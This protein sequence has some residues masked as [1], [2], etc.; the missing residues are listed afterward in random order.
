MIKLKDLSL[1]V[2]VEGGFD[3]SLQDKIDELFRG[4]V[5][6]PRGEW[7]G[8]ASVHISE[9]NGNG[10]EYASGIFRGEKGLA[11]LV[12]LLELFTRD[13]GYYS[14]DSCG[15]HLHV[16][17]VEKGRFLSIYELIPLLSRFEWVEELQ[18]KA[19]KISQRQAKRLENTDN[20]YTNLYRDRADFKGNARNHAKY[21]FI[22][23]HTQGTLEF[24]FIFA[25]ENNEK[26]ETV[27]WVVD[28][29][30][31]ELQKTFKREF[32]EEISRAM[33]KKSFS[34]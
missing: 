19:K 9:G 17:L 22:C 6:H 10:H 8:D 13:N 21:K 23:Y 12:E 15:I 5:D 28:E 18:E 27:K 20:S 4:G 32:K 33:L 26:V 25:S 31:K 1:G 29:V 34:Y 3:V 14:N 30:L 24:R 16:G 7:K 2:E 11:G